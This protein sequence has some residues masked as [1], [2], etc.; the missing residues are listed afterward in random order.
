MFTCWCIVK[1]RRAFGD[2][3]NFLSA[4]F[5]LLAQDSS[6][7]SCWQ[8][9]WRSSNEY[10]QNPS[11]SW[12]KTCWKN[13]DQIKSANMNKNDAF[14]WFRSGSRVVFSRS[15]RFPKVPKVSKPHLGPCPWGRWDRWHRSSQASFLAPSLRPQWGW[16]E[17]GQTNMLVIYILSYIY[18]F[19]Y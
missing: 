15:T 1:S 4:S 10:L 12:N 17:S 9:W 7:H 6:E 8:P 16:E 14:V 5:K 2:A 11:K 18:I 13:T 19:I 3:V